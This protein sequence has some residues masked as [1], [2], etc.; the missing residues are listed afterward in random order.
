MFWTTEMEDWVGGWRPTTGH[1][2]IFLLTGFHMYL[3]DITDLLP[4]R[5][6]IKHR[7]TRKPSIVLIENNQNLV[8]K[9]SGNFEIIN[10]WEPW[11]RGTFRQRESWSML[12]HFFSILPF[13][14]CNTILKYFLTTFVVRKMGITTD[15]NMCLMWTP[16]RSGLKA[17]RPTNIF[18]Y[19]GCTK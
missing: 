12:Y 19:R 9:K 2:C 13:K 10:L 6:L 3:T 14:L 5:L 11:Q 16:Y 15:A 17:E 18:V 4:V 8:R 1:F 7:K